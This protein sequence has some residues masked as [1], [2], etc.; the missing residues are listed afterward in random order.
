MNVNYMDLLANP[1]GHNMDVMAE[2]FNH[3]IN[4]IDAGNI[5]T[6]L[7][8]GSMDA[9]ESIN[10][11][12]LFENAEI[13]TF[14]PVPFNFAQCQERVANQPSDISDR[15]HLHQMALNNT[16]GPME[17]WALDV[18]AA[19]IKGKLN[20][21][22]ASKYKLLDPDMW[23][24]EHNQQ[25][26]IIVDGYRLDDWAKDNS[27]GHIDGIWMDAQG[28]ELDILMGA[29]SVLENVKFVFTEAGLKPYYE[30]HTMKADMDAF[31]FSKSFIEWRPGTRQAH[32]YEVDMIYLNTKFA[33]F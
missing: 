30:G 6:L 1:T 31:M 24:W 22:I 14:E 33:K 27:I 9:W 29:E 18:E 12:R 13:H 11:A 26:S 25:K 2:R 23:P 3:I 8:I 21:G 19:A 32:E 15:I 7:E 4:K 20:H 17:F 16:T 28:A 5:N 10:M